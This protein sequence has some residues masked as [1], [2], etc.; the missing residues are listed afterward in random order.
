MTIFNFKPSSTAKC[1]ASLVTDTWLIS[2]AHCLVS[3]HHFES[4]P[5][6]KEMPGLELDAE[7]QTTKRG[8]ILVNFPKQASWVAKALGNKTQIYIIFHY[9]IISISPSLG[10]RKNFRSF[11]GGS[12]FK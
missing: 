4:K 2:A 9:F 11:A 3:K 10:E 8:D 5:C 6:L 7:C 12:R 1:T